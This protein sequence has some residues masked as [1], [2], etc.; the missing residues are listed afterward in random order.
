[1]DIS[2]DLSSSLTP[3]VIVKSAKVCWPRAPSI[4]ASL[5]SPPTWYQ[6][7]RW[8]CSSAAHVSLGLF[9]DPQVISGTK[10]SLLYPHFWPLTNPHIVLPTLRHSPS[11][12]SDLHGLETHTENKTK[13][14]A[15]ICNPLIPSLLLNLL[16][17]H[18]D[19][20]AC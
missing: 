3:P 15:H 17:S 1:M 9:F 7:H 6:D 5:S 8:G 11:N 4:L 2:S 19:E 10:T 18:P 13:E 16:T 14:D 12:N 20:A